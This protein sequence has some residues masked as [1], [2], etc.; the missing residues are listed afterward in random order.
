MIALL[1]LL[2]ALS[3]ELKADRLTI[4]DLNNR[5]SS[6]LGSLVRPRSEGKGFI[7]ARDRPTA[8]SGS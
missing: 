3:F 5:Y 4:D 6:M 2:F 8:L 7:S 1:R